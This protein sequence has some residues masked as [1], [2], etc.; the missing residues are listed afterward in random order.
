MFFLIL[1][2]SVRLFLVSQ[3]PLCVFLLLPTLSFPSPYLLGRIV[4]LHMRD[5]FN[6]K[7]KMH[8]LISLPLILRDMSLHEK[9]KTVPVTLS[10]SLFQFIALPQILPLPFQILQFGNSKARRLQRVSSIYHFNVWNKV[11]SAI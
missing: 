11:G 3:A 5:C 4:P 9:C 7:S 1:W 10:L 6:S 2:V 8:E